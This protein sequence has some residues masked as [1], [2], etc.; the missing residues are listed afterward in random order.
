MIEDLHI[1]I[2]QDAVD[3]QCHVMEVPESI[4]ADVIVL[5]VQMNQEV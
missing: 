4:K 2:D 1:V 3:H 5:L